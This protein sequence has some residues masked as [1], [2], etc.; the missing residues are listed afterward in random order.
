MEKPHEEASED[1]EKSEDIEVTKEEC[2]HS[3]CQ[4]QLCDLE[5]SHQRTKQAYGEHRLK[6]QA[7][8]H[9]TQGPHYAGFSVT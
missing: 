6:V 3:C 2:S 8:I 4:Q 5:E 1:S 9:Q 7:L